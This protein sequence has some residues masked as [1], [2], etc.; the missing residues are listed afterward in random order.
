VLTIAV[1][2]D[3][4]TDADRL[5]QAA[6]ETYL[7]PETTWLFDMKEVARRDLEAVRRAMS[8]HGFIGR[9]P[10]SNAK[11][12][13]Q[14]C[15]TFSERYGGSPLGLLEEYD[16]NAEQIWKRRK[17]L[18]KLPSL[19][20]DKISLVWLRSLKDVAGI[21]LKNI[22]KLPIPVDIHIARATH[23][24]IY[25][26]NRRPQVDAERKEIAEVWSRICRSLDEPDI[27]PLAL[28]EPL[29][30]LSREGCSGTDN[31][32]SCSRASECVAVEFCVFSSGE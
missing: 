11:C 8:V 13:Y 6:V 16:Y 22:E 25:R 30:F 29:W 24:L 18:G 1:T 3:R 4:Q 32:D 26:S 10:N 21:E 23:R 20:G 31:R 2:I 27:Y 19:T 7:D 5:W 15:K 12:I 14:V 9:Y 17:H 28:D